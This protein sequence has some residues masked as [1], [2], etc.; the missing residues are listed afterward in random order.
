[1][2]MK[3]VPWVGVGLLAASAGGV[4]RVAA[5]TAADAFLDPVAQELF[6]SARATWASVDESI[7]RYTA[8]IKQRIAAKL[9]TPLKDRIL[10][11]NETAVR[12]FWDKDYEPVVQV[13][14]TRS[15]YPGRSIAVREGDFDWLDE[16]PFDR[17]FDPGGDRLFFGLD[18]GNDRNV[19]DED[20]AEEGIDIWLAHPLAPGADTLY[21]Y[22]SGDTLTLSLPDGR[23]LQTIQ[24]DVLPRVADSRR[25]TGSLWIEPETGALVRAVYRLSRQ[26]DAI[27]D[28][29][30]LQVEEEQGSFRYVPGLFMPWTFDL[31]MIAVDYSLWDFTVWLPRSMRLE[32]E[33]AAGILK[34]PISMDVSYELESVTTTLD[35]ARRAAAAEARLI[36]RH[37][38]STE[39]FSIC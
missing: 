13:L 30:E 9:R 25:I 28:V 32:G 19:D 10:Y 39:F 11:R 6:Q 27:R 35:L 4:E 22:E 37:F 38:E 8:L 26:F 24:L 5:Q 33:A 17:P 2:R 18:G 7:A 31:T 21:R 36:E 20:R 1:M 15:Q 16:L 34:M 29:P 14:G 3:T 12:A 23:R